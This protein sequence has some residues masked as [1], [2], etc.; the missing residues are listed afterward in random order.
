MSHALIW[1]LVISALGVVVVRRRA[2]AIGLVALQSLLLGAQAIGDASG[3]S[4]ALLVAGIVL[5]AKAIV[6][7]VLLW[8]VVGRT[9]EERRMASERHP[10]VRLTVALAAALAIVALVPRFGLADAGVEHAAVGLVALGIATAIVRRPA[11]FQALGF[12]IA[13]NGLY[14][15]ALGGARRAASVHRAGTRVRP[16][17]RRVRRRRV[18]REDPR[19]AR[20]GRHLAA[21]RPA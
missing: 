6:L 18:Q 21:G 15:A 14:L 13:E 7:P 10:L 20:D 19:G 2:V 4:A 1:A 9:R 3:Q 8:V 17:R 11:I 16:D 5:L 12:L